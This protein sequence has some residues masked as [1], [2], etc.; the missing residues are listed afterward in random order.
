MKPA[1]LDGIARILR[2]TLIV[3]L[4]VPL[5]ACARGKT[6]AD[7]RK[8]QVQPIEVSLMAPDQIKLSYTMPGETR[9]YSPGVDFH[10]AENVLRITIRRCAIKAQCAVMARAPMPP[11]EAWKPEVVLPYHGE[12]IVLVYSDGEE[13]VRL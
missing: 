5:A 9:F 2:A 13:R 3:A 8:D 10:A 6:H 4:L 1:Y 7:Y 12:T 11:A